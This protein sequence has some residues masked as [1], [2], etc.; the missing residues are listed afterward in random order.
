LFQGPIK[1]EL[2][3]NWVVRGYKHVGMRHVFDIARH[4]VSVRKSAVMDGGFEIVAMPVATA[5]PTPKETAFLRHNL[6][7]RCAQETQ[8]AFIGRGRPGVTDTRHR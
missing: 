1:T 6:R 4:R 8:P 5:S 2:L 3:P 7:V